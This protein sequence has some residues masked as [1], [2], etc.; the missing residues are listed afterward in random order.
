MH[1]QR[2]INLQ[3]NRFLKSDE[4]SIHWDRFSPRNTKNRSIEFI[5]CAIILANGTSP[6][7]TRTLVRCSFDE[8]TYNMLLNLLYF[9]I[10][11]M[12]LEI[13]FES[14]SSYVIERERERECVCVCV[15]YCVI[16]CKVI[17]NPLSVHGDSRYVTAFVQQQQQQ[18]Q[19]QQSP[20]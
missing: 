6:S 17:S 18:Q 3:I 20:L 1:L 10:E 8:V 16:F 14:Y 12:R 13:A 11:R 7:C 19:Q 4:L 2:Q 15:I 5:G 9:K